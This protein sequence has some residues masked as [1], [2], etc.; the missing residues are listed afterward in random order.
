[1]DSAPFHSPDSRT[2]LIQMDLRFVRVEDDS[3]CIVKEE[4][5]FSNCDFIDHCG[6][7]RKEATN[8]T[9]IQSSE[10]KSASEKASLVLNTGKNDNGGKEAMAAE[11]LLKEEIKTEVT[12]TREIDYEKTQGNT[13]F[14]V[15]NKRLQTVKIESCEIN[16]EEA[17][18]EKHQSSREEQENELLQPVKEEEITVEYGQHDDFVGMDLVKVEIVEG[19]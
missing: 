1:M 13:K 12:D 14:I 6:G 15:E 5:I 7:S 10:Y 16:V 19:N 8:T 18:L 9:E 3:E 2:N 17:L 11:I 4:M